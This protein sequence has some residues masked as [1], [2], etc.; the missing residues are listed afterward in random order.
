MNTANVNVKPA[1]SCS[2]APRSARWTAAGSVIASFGICAACC[3]LP[4]TLIVLGVGGAWAGRLEALAPF[5]WYFVAATAVLLGFG[6]YSVYFR[7]SQCT[8]GPQCTVCRTGRGVKVLL[9][10]ATALAIAG[11][12]FEQIEPLLM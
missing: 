12:A 9:W 1:C 3:L 5:K 6:F 4:M 7:S 2:S 11:L 8:A 10:T